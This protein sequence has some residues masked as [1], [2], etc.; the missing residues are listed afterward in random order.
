M[1]KI[2]KSF[3]VLAALF[4][5]TMVSAQ[6]ESDQ[7]TL[8]TKIADVLAGLPAEDLEEF[9]STMAE[10][11]AMGEEG[12]LAMT[13]MLEDPET[14]NNTILEY[15]LGG[16]S[17]YVTQPEMETL[18][19]M[20]I[21]AY[22]TAL[23]QTENVQNKAFIIRR[24]KMVGGND[25]ISCLEPYL[26]EK[27][28]CAPA[29]K[30]LVNINSSAANEALLQALKNSQGECQLSLVQAIGDVRYKEAV[31]TIVRLADSD[32]NKFRKLSLY[33]L[34][35]IADPASGDILETAA[36]EDDF[37]FDTDNATS[38]YLLF[39]KRL[40][41]Q[42]NTE[43]AEKV[44]K[45]IS[46]RAKGENRL[47]S[48]TAALKLLTDIRGEGSVAL[49]REA[50]QD[51][52]P[53]FR[54]VAL[55][56]ASDY[57]TPATS[58][59]WI[60]QARKSN[61]QVEAEII[62]MLGDN[63]AKSV[64]PQIIKALNSRSQI[65]QM[66]AIGAL[67]KIGDDTAV[68]HLLNVLR[69]ANKQ[70]AAAVRD[71]FFII[72][73]QG[74]TDAVADALPQMNAEARAALLS[75][76]GRRA[77]SDRISDVINYATAENDLVRTASL[78][79]LL[80]M[81][82]KEDLPRLFSLLKEAQQPK[83]IEMLQQA[84]IAG[85]DDYENQAQKT[86]LVLEE[87]K[88]LSEEK[89]VRYFPVLAS[90]GGEEA[91]DAVASEFD[92]T[93]YPATKA[94]AINALSA[95]S[96]AAAATELFRVSQDEANGDYKDEALKG[97]IGAVSRSKD[98]TVQK[99]LL[100]RKA[101]AVSAIQHKK[102]ILQ[103]VGN[104][105]DLHALT[106][107][108]E[109]LDEPLLQQEAAR[110]VMQV[111]L[112]NN[113]HGKLVEQLLNK[114]I[115][116]LEGAESQ[117]L[118][119]SIVKYLEGMSKEEGI[120]ALFNGEDLS[121]WKGLVANPVERA[122][123]GENKLNEKQQVANNEMQESWKV[124]NG[125]LI[126]T[127]KGDNIATAEKYGDFEL[128]LDWKIFDDGHK[129]GDAGIYL[130]GTPQVQMWDISRVEDGAQV[131]SGGLYNNQVN[132]SDPLLVADNPL[133]EWNHF[134]ILMKGD[135]VTVYLNGKLVTDNVILEN[136]WDRGSPIFPEEQ[137][138]LQA[139]GSRVAYRDIY[140]REIPG[141]EPFK[142]S[143]AEKKEGFEI[144]FDGTNMHQ[145]QGNT[146]DYAIENGNMVVR[147]PEFGSGGN[148]FT[149]KQYHD[150]VYRFE[151]KLTPGANNGL[152]IRAPLEGDVAY[153]G[154]ELQILDNTADI[155][156]DL[157]EYQY[158]GSLYGVAAANKGYLK[159]V[160]EWNYEEVIVDGNKIKVILNGHTILE[161][162]ISEPV[163][164][165]TL[166]GEDHPGLKRA[167]GHIG[168]LGH[169]S[170]VWFRNIRIKEL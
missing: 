12:L 65:V 31:S 150:F 114:T 40:L 70:K 52:N 85:I 142:L 152:G 158:H 56:F 59:D 58:E 113:Y 148:L 26:N 124:N 82:G 57:I 15:A 122:K 38:A 121:G 80:P 111:A 151:F 157:E 130:R 36:E 127:G 91:L 98:P 167:K 48:R 63:D 55:K 137:I 95:W 156:K 168:F 90:I 123:M 88:D 34:A 94:A 125:E 149:K 32:N 69:N 21:N 117:Y 39:G 30:A 108:G 135:R 46:K 23:E 144:L 68:P 72:D 126:F 104:L 102:L 9:S 155:Y 107:A 33:A 45:R 165:G 162:D 3:L 101:F 145:W 131:G 8:S 2:I 120:V 42:G 147:K 84:A 83:E 103:E 51:D 5:G 140:I 74:L 97:Y 25:A 99:L 77:A 81:A 169:D 89:K 53:E 49:L 118:K 78:A 47:Y 133:G 44:A 73:A 136:Y 119:Q 146:K 160:G 14:G 18:R 19:Q 128:I 153:Q 161:T 163:E 154:M 79:A 143:E 100:L 50:T 106:F 28:L 29:A 7:R 4:F 71:A 1:K 75:V 35:N 170:E 134:R 132:E 64:A 92:I 41:E 6:R 62:T 17:F 76:L 86:T 105:G 24:L 60:K 20:S 61:P 22:C 11:G 13:K 87:M 139:H 129:E 138:E 166:D 112:N 110:A 37:S 66:A 115:E 164:N 159:P 109:Y 67:G 93:D 10:I 54:A 27:P 43:A 16:F 96:D 141:M 116:V